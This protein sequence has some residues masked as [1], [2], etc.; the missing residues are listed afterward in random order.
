MNLLQKQPAGQSS[1]DNWLVFRSVY[2]HQEQG[3]ING[4]NATLQVNVL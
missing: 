3:A 2:I 4:T 1:T